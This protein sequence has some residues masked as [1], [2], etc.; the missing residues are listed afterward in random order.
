M[1]PRPLADYVHHLS[2]CPGGGDDRCTCGAVQALARAQ[3]AIAELDD[4]EAYNFP[5]YGLHVQRKALTEL[6]AFLYAEIGPRYE[7]ERLFDELRFPE[8]KLH[9]NPPEAPGDGST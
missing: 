9:R 2:G 4:E 3:K 7:L 5:K 8:D 6:I 1:K